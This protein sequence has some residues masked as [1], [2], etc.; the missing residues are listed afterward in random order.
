[1][2]NA[3]RIL[4]LALV[5]G[6]AAAPAQDRTDAEAEATLSAVV[7]VQSRMLPDARTAETLGVRREG[8]G[9]LVRE[10]YVLTIGYLVI[11]AE[12]IAVTASSGSTVPALL[13]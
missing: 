10:G 6:A 1:M 5:L 2:A 7:R 9:I 13:A 11:E 4:L 8:S 3:L 12:S